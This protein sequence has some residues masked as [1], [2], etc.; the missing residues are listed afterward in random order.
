MNQN[1]LLTLE[2]MFYKN[3]WFKECHANNEFLNLKSML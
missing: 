1:T 2:K 3:T